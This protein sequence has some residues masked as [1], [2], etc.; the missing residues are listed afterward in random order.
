MTKIRISEMLLQ[1]LAMDMP[2]ELRREFRVPQLPPGV[3]P[4]GAAFALD[5]ALPT[6]GWL[7]AQ[8]GWCG[9]G[10]PGYTYLAELAQRSEYSAPTFTI[11]S[12]MTREWIR[13]TG[14][15][16][17]TTQELTDAFEEFDVRGCF[18]AMAVYD[19]FFGCGHIYI[20]IKN[21]TSDVRRQLPLLY[22]P[23]TIAK[24][25]LEALKAVE[26]VWCTPNAYNS[27]DPTRDDFYRPTSWYV[28][29][30]RTHATR[31]LTFVGRPLPDLLK[32]SYNFGGMSLS[33]LIEPYVVRWLKTVDSVNRLIS[34]FSVS[35]VAT[36][37]QATLEGESSDDTSLVNRARL[38]TQL[39]DSR[40]LML[41]D[42]DSEEF[43]QFNTP[44]SGL[45]DLQAQA[46]EHMA[47]PTHIPLVKLTGLTPSGLNASSEGEIK[48]F[49]D[50]VA[51]EQ[52]VLFTPHLTSVLRI[53]QCHLWG[54]IDPKIGFEWVPLDSPTDKE[55]SEMRKS[56]TERDTAYT[57]MGAVGVDEVRERIRTDPNSGYTFLEGAPPD[58][59]MLQEHELGEESADNA[60]A[61]SEESKDADAQR[62]KQ[63][64]KSV[65]P[66]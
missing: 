60:H 63:V 64:D 7:N 43:F 45:S 57:T 30:K 18:R 53:M 25:S 66:A 46:Q 41:L 28:M 34:N 2:A 44:L 62:A 14:A 21:Q 19:G 61:R 12:E 5:A 52:A 37:M 42:K 50:H 58:P 27:N 3:V 48:V 65:G 32:P 16:E 38:F 8:T 13:F 39:R 17:E 51:S 49:Y 36:N 22:E 40:N 31:L 15:D 47:A 11:A 59:P 10:F 20:R 9:L 1:K 35:G 55:L 56:D 26:P 24:G 4:A 29:G 54:K 33:Q 6:M 23:E